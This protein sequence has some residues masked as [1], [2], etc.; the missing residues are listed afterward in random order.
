[1]EIENSA[2][3]IPSA[4]GHANGDAALNSNDHD[5]QLSHAETESQRGAEPLMAQ[6]AE[7]GVDRKSSCDSN[8][9]TYGNVRKDDSGDESIEFADAVDEEGACFFSLSPDKIDDQPNDIGMYR[10]YICL[11]IG[12]KIHF[13]ALKIEMFFSGHGK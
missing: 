6:S 9:L 11:F 4:A 10:I 8:I 7:I 13:I 3:N 2:P 5:V 1:M 12:V